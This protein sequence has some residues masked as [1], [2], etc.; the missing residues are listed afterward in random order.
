MLTN[1]I[2][3][4]FTILGLMLVAAGLLALSSMAPP[5]RSKRREVLISFAIV[6]GAAT[7]AIGVLIY[8]GTP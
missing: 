6:L 1:L 5:G 7:A 4:L 3:G 8:G 2:A